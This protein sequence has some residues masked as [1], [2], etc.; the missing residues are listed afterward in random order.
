[1]HHEAQPGLS[2]DLQ[3]VTALSFEKR[4]SISEMLHD[5]AEQPFANREVG[6]AAGLLEEMVR[7]PDMLVIGTYS[8]A[9]TAGG[10]DEGVRTMI[11]RGMVQA[12]F[13]TGALNAHGFVRS[14][15]MHHFFASK[16]VSDLEYAQMKMN[17]IYRVLEPES[18]LDHVESIFHEILTDTNPERVHSSRYFLHALGKYLHDNNLGPGILRSAYEKGVPVITPAFFDS[19]LGL[20]VDA[21]D[22][23]LEEAGKP[24]FKYN[25]MQDLY[26]YKTLIREAVRRGNKLGIFTVG[27][28]VPRNYAQQVGPQ[29]EIL[30]DR[31]LERNPGK[32]PPPVAMFEA[33]MRFCPDDVNLGHLS[34]C[35]YEEGKSW[36]KFTANAR[37]VEVLQDAFVTWPWVL[38]GVLQRLDEKPAEP[39]RIYAGLEM[40]KEVSE[41]TDR[42][43]NP[44]LVS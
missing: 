38:E 40:V 4:K 20:D 19:E 27:G 41:K 28:G 24:A 36:R 18:N 34:G 33:A 44:N 3:E 32:K 13:A 23:A 31:F 9:L 35:T 43:F 15:G 30:R 11:D 8:G 5:F 1:M 10:M 25:D 2:H 29:T 7:D 22:E 26:F 12:V 16:D 42:R 17:R 39:K 14:V 37:T 21:F 6:Q